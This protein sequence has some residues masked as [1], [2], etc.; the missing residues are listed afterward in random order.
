MSIRYIYIYTFC[1]F[2]WSLTTQVNTRC[3]IEGG[4]LIQRSRG[5]KEIE[6]IR[7][8]EGNDKLRSTFLYKDTK[9]VRVYQRTKQITR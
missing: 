9:A 7:E 6:I 5:D 4:K 8:F 2:C 1:V 3:T